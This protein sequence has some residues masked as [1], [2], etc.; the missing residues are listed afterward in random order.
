MG[1]IN[2]IERVLAA[3]AALITLVGFVR[4]E[5]GRLRRKRKGAGSPTKKS[6]S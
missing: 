1:W 2:L 4:S 6:G 3:L 5:I